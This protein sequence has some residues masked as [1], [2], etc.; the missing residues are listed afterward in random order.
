MEDI[1]NKIA[2]LIENPLKEKGYSLYEIKFNYSKPM[3]SL[4][5]SV[6]RIKPIS[7]DEIVEVSDLVSSILDKEDPIEGA[8][9]LDVSSAGAEKRIK[10]EELDNYLSNY[11][12]IHL[13]HPYKG[14]NILEGTLVDINDNEVTL[15]VIVK[16][17]KNKIIL[18]RGNIDKARL[19]IKF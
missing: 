4:S 7:L 1:A 3:S 13:T 15:E 14:E 11:I 10:I 19:A 5:I 8:Y 12:N 6:D 18:P 16:G 17:K 2:A 9:N